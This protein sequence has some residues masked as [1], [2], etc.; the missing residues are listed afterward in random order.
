MS[1]H[2]NN[3]K[4][5]INRPSKNHVNK[6]E[7]RGFSRPLFNFSFISKSN[8]FNLRFA[9]QHK[10]YGKFLMQKLCLL[11]QFNDLASCI[12]LPRAEGIE[13]LP[14]SEVNIRVNRI[15]RRSKRWSLCNPGYY[16]FRVKSRSPYRVIGK[17]WQEK[18]I[19]YILAFDPT[20]SA[21][22]G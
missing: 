11:S 8:R 5:R 1:K 18:N 12:E 4:L 16:S 9:K 10:N 3:R 7:L 2:Y 15:F 13:P 20:H 6:S 19:F 21:Y 22:K 14:D 17:I